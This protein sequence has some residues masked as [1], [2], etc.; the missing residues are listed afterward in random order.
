MSSSSFSCVYCVLFHGREGLYNDWV[1]PQPSWSAF[2]A[3]E[4]GHGTLQVNATTAIWKWHR[5]DDL[6]PV[7][8]DS[9]IAH[10]QQ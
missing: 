2:H 8:S 5:D 1:T 7:V 3:A 10:K 6:E 9:V 4:Y